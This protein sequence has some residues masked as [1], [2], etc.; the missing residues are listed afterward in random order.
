MIEF[1]NKQRII[2]E[3]VPGK[4]VTLC[5]LISKPDKELYS[6]LGLM[7]AKGSVGILTITP[8]EGAIIGADV[9]VKTANVKIGFLDRFNG[10]LVIYGDVAA[11]ESALKNV[12]NLMSTQLG[13]HPC[14]FTKT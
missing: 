2:Q 1:D 7:D 3:Y 14:P 8:G 11:V 12:V 9:A 4:Q 6:K 13:C 10:S 5:H